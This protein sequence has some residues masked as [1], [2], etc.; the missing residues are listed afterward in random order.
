MNAAHRS[1]ADVATFWFV[2]L[3]RSTALVAYVEYPGGQL[4]RFLCPDAGWQ[5][6]LVDAIGPTFMIDQAARPEL[7]DGDEAGALEIGGF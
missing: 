4:S 3:V 5:L 2:G 6:G 1:E 7:R